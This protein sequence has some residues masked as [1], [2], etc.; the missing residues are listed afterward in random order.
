MSAPA[1]FAGAARGLRGP[2]PPWAVN[3]FFQQPVRSASG[4]D[5]PDT[6]A[7]RQRPVKM[8]PLQLPTCHD[9]RSGFHGSDVDGHPPSNRRDSRGVLP[10]GRRS[11]RECATS[12]VRSN[13][14][15]VC[16]SPDLPSSLQCGGRPRDRRAD[17]AGGHREYSPCG[18][19]ASQPY[20][21]SSGHA[22][23]RERLN[24][25]GDSQTWFSPFAMRLSFATRARTRRIDK[26]I[27]SDCGSAIH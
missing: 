6:R 15:L 27:D 21:H 4:G 16:S 2:S 17:G 22:G 9:R 10:R 11:S 12:H 3:A 18:H 23:G 24:V 8:C 14:G 19:C 7:L 1:Q 20:G 5:R 25:A 13:C 26:N